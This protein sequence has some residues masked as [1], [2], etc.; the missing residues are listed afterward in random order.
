MKLALRIYLTI[1]TT[2]FILGMFL[3]YRQDYSK[4][5]VLWKIENDFDKISDPGSPE[6]EFIVKKIINRYQSFIKKNAKTQFNPKAQLELANVFVTQNRYQEARDIY[7]DVINKFKI[8]PEI[9]AKAEYALAQSYEKENNWPKA[10]TIY[11][12]IIREYPITSTGF[13]IPYYLGS[14]YLIRGLNSTASTAFTEASEF[15]QNIAS[16]YP[17]SPLGYSSLQM[18]IKSYLAL[19]NWTD[20]LYAAKQLL[21]QYPLAPTLTDTIFLIR[22]IGLKKL[23]NTDLILTIYK[24]FIDKNKGHPINSTLE[25]IIHRISPERT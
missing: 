1:L 3:E 24:D 21:F 18:L 2:I 25:K 23:K 19:G 4:E 12:S 7:E 22:D 9:V 14:F 5:R 17:D 8:N 6:N 13:S 16:S 15:Y 10:V 20:A 11:R